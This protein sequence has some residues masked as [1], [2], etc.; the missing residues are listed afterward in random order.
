MRREQIN[1]KAETAKDVI[2]ML[3]CSLFLLI[4]IALNAHLSRENLSRREIGSI[5][6]YVDGQDAALK[7]PYQPP[8]RGQRETP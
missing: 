4:F 3:N 1:E 7:Q 2:N 8:D 6:V 5:S